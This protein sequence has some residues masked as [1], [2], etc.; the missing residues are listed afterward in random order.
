MGES[1]IVCSVS[2]EMVTRPARRAAKTTFGANAA[3]S[4]TSTATANIETKVT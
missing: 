4:A 1:P 3:V 2:F